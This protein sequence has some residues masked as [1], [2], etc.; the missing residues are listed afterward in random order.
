M[1]FLLVGWDELAE[2]DRG[3]LGELMA[4]RL[5]GGCDV[6]VTSRVGEPITGVHRMY[7]CGY[8]YLVIYI[9]FFFNI[10]KIVVEMCES[11]RIHKIIIRFNIRMQA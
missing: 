3:E 2:G 4:G 5:L 7:R 11:I 1:L 8:I 10:S 9:A 6:I